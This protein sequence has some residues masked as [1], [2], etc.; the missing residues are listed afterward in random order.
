VTYAAGAQSQRYQIERSPNEQP[1]F[2]VVVMFSLFIWFGI[3]VSI[4][5]L[6]YV[7]FLGV[8]FFVAH[9]VFVGHIRGS[10]VKLTPDQFPELYDVVV[11]MSVEMGMDPP[12]A[13]IIQSGGALNALATRFLSSNMI[14]L[15]SDL[16]EACGDNSGARDMIIAHELGHLRCGHLRWRLLT[17]PGLMIPFLGSA[18]SRAREYT[19]DRFG[20]AG[21]GNVNDAMRGLTILAAGPV[22]GA[23]V[24][25]EAFA[26]QREDVNTGFMT[27]AEWL[28]THPPLSKRIAALH[29]PLM[30]LGH[31]SARGSLRA[32]GILVAVFVLIVGGTTAL[33]GVMGV[34][35]NFTEQLASSVTTD[36]IQ[37]VDPTEATQRVQADF[38]RLS[39][40]IEEQWGITGLWPESMEQIRETWVVVQPDEELPIDPFDGFDYGYMLEG[41]T[42]WIWSSGP[43]GDSGTDDDIA[44][45]GP[46]PR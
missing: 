31:E 3:I 16:L 18:L 37:P 25:M 33:V 4:I 43:D 34:M 8:F 15:Y 13:Y 12:E 7:A 39:A 26:R 46:A 9:M 5:G 10:G 11:N 27:L 30:Q 35:S 42:Y 19:C 32:L 22:Y 17:L 40:F 29:P 38:K 6:I 45:E 14:V 28:S 20:L 21:A 23:R 2:A 1:L 41:T 44:Y 24:S 36:A